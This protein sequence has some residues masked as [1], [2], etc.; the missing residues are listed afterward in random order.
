MGAA[1]VSKPHRPGTDALV[2]AQIARRPVEGGGR[3]AGGPAQAPMGPGDQFRPRRELLKPEGDFAIVSRLWNKRT[4][5]M[6][7]WPAGWSSGARPSNHAPLSFLA[8]AAI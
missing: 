6:N 2:E 7:C 8:P 4:I 3:R 5:W 1:I